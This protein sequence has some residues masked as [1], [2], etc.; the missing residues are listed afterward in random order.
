MFMALRNMCHI[1]DLAW[2]G[3]GLAMVLGRNAYPE[4]ALVVAIFIAGRRPN[5]G[6]IRV[7]SG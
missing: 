4:R 6:L 2:P 3:F 1:L 5:L 7:L